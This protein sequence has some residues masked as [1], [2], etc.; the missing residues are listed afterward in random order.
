MFDA[1]HEEVRE[2]F[3]GWEEQHTAI[4]SSINHDR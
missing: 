2:L 1:L 4:Y 3:G